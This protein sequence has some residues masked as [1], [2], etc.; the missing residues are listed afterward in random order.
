MKNSPWFIKTAL[1]SPLI[2]NILDIFPSN[3]D[4]I[5]E[6]DSLTY[7]TTSNNI[8]C[9]GLSDGNATI[10]I[11]GG[12]A[13]YSQNWGSSDPLALSFGMHYYTI[14]DTNGCSLSDS[15][16]ITEPTQLLAS[17]FSTNVT[18]YGGNNGTAVL[19]VSG[20]TPTYL[21]N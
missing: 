14:S 1:P 9:Y 16:F 6:P 12:V 17:I 13:P 19:S 18:C 3:T 2:K 7:S 5:V 4:R 21:E 15:L 8:S 10:N 20:G 11:S